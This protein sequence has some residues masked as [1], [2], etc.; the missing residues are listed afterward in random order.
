MPNSSS[1]CQNGST[2]SEPNCG[3]TND[4]HDTCSLRQLPHVNFPVPIAQDPEFHIIFLSSY[5]KKLWMKHH[6]SGVVPFHCICS[7]NPCSIHEFLKALNISSPEDMRLFSLQ[8][9]YCLESYTQNCGGLTK[10][11]GATKKKSKSRKNSKRGR[12]SPSGSSR[13]GRTRHG[14]DSK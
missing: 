2:N 13:K 12:T 4:G 6:R 9:G 7:A 1:E 8:T 14:Q 3:S 11:S 5:L 10:S